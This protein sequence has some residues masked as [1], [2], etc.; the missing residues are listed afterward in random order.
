M[1]RPF[2]IRRDSVIAGDQPRLMQEVVGH[3]GST[4]EASSIL[5]SLERLGSDTSIDYYEMTPTSAKRRFVGAASVVWSVRA[6]RAE[7]GR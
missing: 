4:E 6:V 2:T 3:T 5:R 1:S 7:L